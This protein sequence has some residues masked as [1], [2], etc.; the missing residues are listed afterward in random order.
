MAKDT[1]QKDAAQNQHYVPKFV[2]RNFLSNADK[3]QV[4]VFDKATS[5]IFTPNIHGIMAER[6]FNEFVIDEQWLAS[7]EPAICD[8][9]DVVLPAYRRVVVNR[10]LDKTDE[11]RAH[12]AYLIAFQFVRTKAQRDRFTQMDNMI[13]DK[14]AGIEQI[15]TELAEMDNSAMLRMRH[16]DFIKESM[17]KFTGLIAIKDLLLMEAPE[18]RTFYLG[19]NPVA[20]HNHEEAHPFWGNIG[21]AIQGIEIYLP[22]TR[23]LILC[24]WCPSIIEKHRAEVEKRLPEYRS[25]LLGKM[26]RGELSTQELRA[27]NERM[28]ELVKPITDLVSKFDNGAPILLGDGEM[29]FHN[30]LQLNSSVRHV[31]CPKG[32]F[33]LA[34][35]FMSDNPSHKGGQIK[36]S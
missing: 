25:A 11:E 1:K 30:S 17:K 28:N 36:T 7:F 19:D 20:M 23:D 13:R 9:E 12:L 35:R 31:I 21:L 27:Y 8:I 24:A 18:N 14:W 29:D 6:R 33:T 32:D 26:M 16:A 3:E 4:T 5:R 34:Q 22:L 2:L 10:C 15:N